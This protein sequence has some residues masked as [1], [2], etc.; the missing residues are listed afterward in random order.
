MATTRRP[1]RPRLMKC[2]STIPN[3]KKPRPAPI[4]SPGASGSSVSPCSTDFDR[5]AADDHRLAHHRRPGARPGDEPARRLR[6]ADRREQRRLHP[7]RRQGG[8]DLALV[9]AGEIDAAEGADPGDQAGVVRHRRG[10][11]LGQAGDLGLEAV[12]AEQLRALLA[13]GL[14]LAGGGG[15][16]EDAAAGE[17]EE[18]GEDR[19]VALLEPAADDGELA[20][21]RKP[22]L[23]HR[24]ISRPTA[25]LGPLPPSSCRKYSRRRQPPAGRL[26]AAGASPAPACPR[27]IDDHGRR[28]PTP[29]APAGPRARR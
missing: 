21:R 17:A 20:A 27:T 5:G 22:R 14:G 19:D 7:A 12:G 15:E 9:A 8:D 16:D 10:V 26:R 3:G 18:L 23:S 1:S 24:G 25:A 13:D 4:I 11:R 2:W 6:R 28:R 29:P